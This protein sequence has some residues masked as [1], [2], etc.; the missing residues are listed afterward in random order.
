MTHSFLPV[1]Q[2]DLGGQELAYVTQAIQEGWISS[3]GRFL[4]RFET[5]F[6]QFCGTRHALACANGTVAIHLL[7]LG[8]GLG[9]GD[10][11]I[12]PSFTYV[13]SAN[14]VT[15]TGA[16]P[17]LVDS[18]PVTW[19]V[20][21]RHVEAAITPRTKAIMAVHLY[22]HPAPMAA[23]L[24]I[25]RRHGIPVIEDAA[26]AHGAKVEGRTVGGLGFAA[27][28]SFYGNK[29]LTTGEGGMVTTDDDALA[30]RLRQL[31]GQG[32][33]PERRY[34]FPLVGYN[35][36]MT[37]LAAALGC[38]QLERA[39][40]LIAH[41]LRIARGYRERL[42]P[43]QERLGLQLASEASWARSVHWLSCILVPA[44]QR[45]LLMTFLA[46]RQIETRPFFPPMHRLPMYAD[47]SF[48]Q[49][50]PL[51]VAEALGDTGINLP[52]YTALSDAD[53]DRICGAILA[54]LER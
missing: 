28:F 4:T 7:L 43:H 27:T 2:P 14:A 16:R 24:D 10:E 48:R 51:P 31:R 23:L 33:D 15:Y 36:R 30:A 1:A 25:G 37:N 35:Y 20:D 38:A 17:V 40:E 53:L 9:P 49:G 45:D 5:E 19:T 39:E 44:A 18:E 13:A 42:A 54:G 26:E 32:M 41:R 6:A 34:W 21:P 8:M 22:G 12:V 3:T 11:V 50:R 52:T 46:E 29:I 47:P